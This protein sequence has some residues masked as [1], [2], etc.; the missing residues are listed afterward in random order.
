M[1]CELVDS[2]N[3]IVLPFFEG[4]TPQIRC[5][6]PCLDYRWSYCTC[7]MCDLR[8]KEEASLFLCNKLGTESYKCLNEVFVIKATSAKGPQEPC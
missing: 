3:R 6:L 7:A 5:K 1:F 8:G 4:A 2:L